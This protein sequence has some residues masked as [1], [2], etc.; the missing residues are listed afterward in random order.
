MLWPPVHVNLASADQRHV[1]TLDKIFQELAPSRSA[2]FA[3]T[4][5]SSHWMSNHAEFNYL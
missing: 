2:P 3:D 1:A 5:G 4:I